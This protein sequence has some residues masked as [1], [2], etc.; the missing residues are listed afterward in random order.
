MAAFI[1]MKWSYTSYNMWSSRPAMV[2]LIV[3]MLFIHYM[4]TLYC[5]NKPC[6]LFGVYLLSKI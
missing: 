6:L 3:T 5:A 1:K 4:D 2:F